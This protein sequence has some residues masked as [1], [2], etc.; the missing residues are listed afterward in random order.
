MLTAA[1]RRIT[2]DAERGVFSDFVF[3]SLDSFIMRTFGTPPFF[4]Q[5]SSVPGVFYR[6]QCLRPC[7]YNRIRQ[8]IVAITPPVSTVIRAYFH[9]DGNFPFCSNRFPCCKTYAG[10]GTPPCNGHLSGS[11]MIVS[12]TVCIPTR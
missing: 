8:G 7:L 4:L 9:S 11:H 2:A 12:P 10:M 6:A 5:F 1:R 3:F